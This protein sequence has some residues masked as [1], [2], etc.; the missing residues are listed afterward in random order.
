MMNARPL[1]T[2]VRPRRRAWRMFASG[3]AHLL[4]AVL[5]AGLLAWLAGRVLNDRF[6]WSQ[7]L[8]FVPTPAALAASM[9]GLVLACRPGPS[10]ARRKRRMALWACVFIVLTGYLLFIEHRFQR[11]DA[12]P[13]GGL[14]VAFWNLSSP[15]EEEADAHA[16]AAR[17]LT[18][19]VVILASP[20]GIP[21]RRFTAL[22]RPP[23][24]TLVSTGLFAIETRRAVTRIRP[25]IQQERMYAVIVEIE[26]EDWLGRPLVVCL[27]DL[28][29]EPHVSR[30]GVAQRLHAA[31]ERAGE[32]APD[33]IVGDLNT[34]RGGGAIRRLF[35][36]LREAFD[37]A[38]HGWGATYPRERPLWHIDRVL[39]GPAVKAIDYD[40]IDPGVGRHRAQAVTIIK[41]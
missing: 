26:A 28:P 19:D 5:W 33:L 9:T 31:L 20:S 34:P 2:D 22:T 4:A 1:R 39:L 24:V 30:M 32:P 35:P 11:S 23:G 21:W 8:W 14:R 37:E 38:G 25:V 41:R 16:E 15:V 7:W 3:A 13:E 40:I 29:S 12:S 17:R 10:R 27:A 18:G 36:T 6:G